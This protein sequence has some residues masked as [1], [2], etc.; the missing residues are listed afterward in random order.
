MGCEANLRAKGGVVL[1]FVLGCGAPGGSDEDTT[2]SADTSGPTTTMTQSTTT[3][4]TETSAADTT[5]SMS[6]GSESESGS[7]DGSDSTGAP[8]ELHGRCALGDRVGGFQIDVEAAYSAFSGTVSDG[9]VPVTVLEEVGA[10]GDCLLLRRNNPFC[11]PLCMPGETCDFD[12][13]CIPYPANHDVGTVTVTGL[14]D[15]VVVEPLE[16][17]FSYFD[18]SLSHPPFDP[19]A[20]LELTATGGDYEAFVLHGNGVAM[21]EPVGDELVLSTSEPVDVQ[22][23]ASGATNS[24]L[25]LAVSVDQH[26]IT[27][28]TLVCDAPDTGSLEISADLVSQFL[29]FGVSG[30]PKADYWLQTA[31]SVEIAPGCVEFVVRSHVQNDLSVSGHTPCNGPADCPDGEMCNMELQTCEPI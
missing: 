13:T 21:V 28:V 8:V 14:F 26:G 25:F 18:T 19:G 4:G 30:Y 23:T 1:A 17:T 15:E 31:D 6:T 2:G 5:T 10:E 24:R 27:P 20:A 9:V 29:A 22:W 3:V 11:D 7:S 16:P 12:G